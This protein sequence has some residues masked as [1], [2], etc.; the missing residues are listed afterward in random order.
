MHACNG[1]WPTVGA[2]GRVTTRFWPRKQLLK[3]GLV[4]KQ[5]S[6]PSKHMCSRC[7]CLCQHGKE[8]ESLPL[9]VQAGAQCASVLAL[10]AVSWVLLLL[11][12]LLDLLEVERQL[13]Q[14]RNLLPAS[15]QDAHT[16][17]YGLVSELGPACAVCTAAS[18]MVR[19]QVVNTHEPACVC[20]PHTC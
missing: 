9:T 20:V 17:Y 8:I 11:H 3:E 18:A 2:T 14:P 5:E 1:Y 19:P 13:Q 12:E 10:V 7:C 6:R 15:T 16:E 4:C